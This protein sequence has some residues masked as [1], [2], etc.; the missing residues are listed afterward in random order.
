MGRM[1]SLITAARLPKRKTEA[2][3]SLLPYH[4]DSNRVPFLN[5][6]IRFRFHLI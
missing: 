1:H 4:Q 3:Q 5:V 6:Y 2:V